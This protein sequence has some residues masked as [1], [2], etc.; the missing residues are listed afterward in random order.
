MSSVN[1]KLSENGHDPTID[2]LSKQ[3]SS[4]SKKMYALNTLLI[5]NVIYAVSYLP[6]AFYAFISSVCTM[7]GNLEA[8]ATSFEYFGLLSMLSFSNS[9]INAIV[10]VYRN[11]RIR[12]YFKNN[13]NRFSDRLCSGK[14]LCKQAE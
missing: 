3:K 1:T 6:F 7:D 5:L 4:T 12:T 13:V 2:G 11:K 8:W 9:G 14:C 10:Y